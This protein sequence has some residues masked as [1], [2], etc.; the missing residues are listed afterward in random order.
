MMKRALLVALTVAAA[1]VAVG[2]GGDNSG[3]Q[4]SKPDTDGAESVEPADSAAADAEDG[5]WEAETSLVTDEGWE[6]LVRVRVEAPDPDSDTRC[7][8]PAPPGETIV[9]F[10]VTFTND[11]D[12]KAPIPDAYVY[13][14]ASE[15]D[16]GVPGVMWEPQGGCGP[17][18]GGRVGQTIAS[19]GEYTASG[20]FNGVRESMA[21]DTLVALRIGQC[22][23]GCDSG[24]DLVLRP[25]GST[26][27]EPSAITVCAVLP[28]DQYAFADPSAPSGYSGFEIDL[29]QYVGEQNGTDI[30]VLPTEF[31]GI[32]TAVDEGGCDVVA[33]SVTITPERQATLGMTQPVF[34]QEPT[35]S[36]GFV[37]RADDQKTLA[38]LNAGIDDARASGELQRLYDEYSVAPP[39]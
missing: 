29:L 10:S 27:A 28:N 33:A 6:Y 14:K 4:S 34:N 18:T 37:T 17:T 26:S 19:D 5:G 38:L 22:I 15:T 11:S 13:L 2:C 7:T 35:Y 31:D 21:S 3:P 32:F 1:T 23:A 39:S 25:S 36:N 9:P 20:V 8:Q 16:P 30:T 24:S 12:R